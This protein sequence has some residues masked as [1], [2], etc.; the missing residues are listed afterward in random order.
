[1]THTNRRHAFSPIVDALYAHQEQIV[2]EKFCEMCDR[3]HIPNSWTVQ[4][5]S[6]L[7]YLCS[8]G[9]Y[10]AWLDYGRYDVPEREHD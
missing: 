8:E 9:C 7:V 6:G 5:A 1:M 4:K 3:L 2:A 10:E